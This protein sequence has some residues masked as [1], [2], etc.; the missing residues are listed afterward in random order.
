MVISDAVADT[1]GRQTPSKAVVC[2]WIRDFTARTSLGTLSTLL[3]VN[4]KTVDYW[5]SGRLQPS[6]SH[7]WLIIWLSWQTPETIEQMIRDRIR[8]IETGIY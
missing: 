8:A 5:N 6:R 4:R 3:G 7:A 1:I 2:W